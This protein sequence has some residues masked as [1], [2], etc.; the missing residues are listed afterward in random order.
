MPLQSDADLQVL[1]LGDFVGGEHTADAWTVD[2][3]RLLH[4]DVL[5]RFDRGLEVKGSKARRRRQNHKI[6]I[7][8]EYFFVSIEAGKTMSFVHGDAAG[9]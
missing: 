5:A 4:E 9:L 7:A 2:G 8:A 3:H 6:D 1:L